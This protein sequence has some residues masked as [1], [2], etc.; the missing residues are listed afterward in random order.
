M[1]KQHIGELNAVPN[2]ELPDRL[3]ATFQIFGGTRETAFAFVIVIDGVH[4]LLRIPIFRTT[5]NMG[6]WDLDPGPGNETNVY[7]AD[8]QAM[9][10]KAVRLTFPLY[11][12]IEAWMRWQ[13][14]IWFILGGDQEGVFYNEHSHYPL[15][16][17]PAAI[18][19]RHQ[20][21]PQ[22]PGPALPIAR[23]GD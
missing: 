4:E 8:G 18:R 3:S 19:R 16:R 22:H 5:T 6:T 7:L 10:V 12:P 23:E 21:H 13:A 17:R 11:E 15:H 2:A 9:H 14:I 20:Y 1:S